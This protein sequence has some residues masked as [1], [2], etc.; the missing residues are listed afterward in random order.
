MEKD[1]P[2]LHMR[3]RAGMLESKSPLKPLFFANPC[4]NRIMRPQTAGSRTDVETSQ[5]LRLHKIKPVFVMNSSLR[6]D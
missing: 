6:G 2:Y 1:S 3:K 4:W 5:Q